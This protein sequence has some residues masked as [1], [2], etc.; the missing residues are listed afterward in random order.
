VAGPPAL[1]VV[2]LLLPDISGFEVIEALAADDRTRHVPVLVLTGTDLTDLDRARLRQR[3]SAV[4]GK[5]DLLRGELIAAVDRA[6]HRAG[7]R[8]PGAS[9]PEGPTILVVDDHDLNRQ[10]ARAILERKGYTVTEAEDGEAALAMARQS[11]PALIL[12][13][14]AMPRKDGY[15]A[16]RELKAEPGT[17]EVPI[18]A[19]TAL[20]MRG[21][22]AKA[23]AAGIDAYLTKPI[24]R[25]ALEAT[26]DRFLGGHGSK[27]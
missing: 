25:G 10:L 27:A 23:L 6:T 20:A 12:M 14:L 22:E 16:A 24:D 19:L 1:A 9:R 15:T 4:A 3:V 21:D 18:V 7:R 8:P 5:G 11:R 17:A 13:D 2:D 26:V